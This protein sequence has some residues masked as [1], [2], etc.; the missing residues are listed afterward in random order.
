ML[1]DA[2]RLQ[3]IADASPLVTVAL[4][5]LLLAILHRVFGPPTLDD[6]ER[7]WESGAFDRDRVA[8]YLNA[9]RHRFDLFD[10]QRPFY[11]S[12]SLPDKMLKSVSKLALEYASGNNPALF[13]NT[14][15][16]KRYR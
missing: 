13:D 16:T 1:S 3:E 14:S 4:Y 2:H 7:L 11:Q 15:T 8:E 9:W 12:P 10:E 6:W 5:R